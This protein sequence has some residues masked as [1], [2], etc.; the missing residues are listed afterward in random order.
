MAAVVDLSRQTAGAF[1]DN[2]TAGNL[3]AELWRRF[4]LTL[5]YTRK[6]I[7]LA[8]N[9]QYG[10]PFIGERAGLALDLTKGEWTVA[11]VV[12]N[13]PAGEAGVRLGDAVLAIDDKPMDQIGLSEYRTLF[14]KD[15]G[16][17]FRLRLRSVDKSTREVT[18]TLRDLI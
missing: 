6:K 3:G 11:T 16:T 4:T 8:R 5:D 9:P 2:Q 7:Y 13:G 15:V 12:A 1:A 17:M 10:D 14:R 18:L